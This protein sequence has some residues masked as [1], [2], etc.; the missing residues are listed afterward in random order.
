MAKKRIDSVTLE[1]LLHKLWQIADEAGIV[2]RRVSG[3][4]VVIEAKDM[5]AGLCDASGHIITSG[6]G[7]SAHCGVA[8][9]SVEHL[10]ERYSENPG[11]RDGDAFFINDPYICAMHQ[12][13]AFVVAPI[14]YQEELVAW[15]VTMTHLLDIG[16]ADPGG[17]TP[18]AREV[19]QEGIRIGGIKIAEGGMIRRDVIDSIVNM[20]R[21][22]GIVELDL[23]AQV[24]ASTT[25]KERLKELI[26]H[27]GMDTFKAVC[28][29][30]IK[31]S[32]L[33]LRARIAELPDGRWQSAVYVDDDSKTD[34]V[35]QIFVT[36]TKEGDSLT[37]DYTGT[38]EQAPSY[39]NVGEVGGQG[40]VFGAVAPLL[41]YDMPWSQ[42]VLNP[43]NIIIPKGTLVRAKFPT[44]C[45]LGTLCGGLVGAGNAAV[46]AVS[47][48]LNS[49]G[50]YEE[51]DVTALW[52]AITGA[53]I[54]AG[55]DQYGA[56]FVANF[57]DSEAA[58]GGA[59]PTGDGIDSGGHFFIP[60]GSCA[61]VET[62]EVTFPILYLYR[63]QVTDS[64][65]AGRERGGVGGEWGLMLHDAPEGEAVANIF[66]Y[67]TEAG[68]NAGI[69]GGYPGIG[70]RY[71]IVR[72]SDIIERLGRGDLPESIEDFK[73]N[74]EVLKINELFTLKSGDVF[75]FRWG[76]GGGYGDPIDRDTER[77]QQDVI[78]RLVSLTAARD[79]Y[80]AGIDPETIEIDVKKTEQ[81]REVIRQERLRAQKHSR[82]S[83]C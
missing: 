76:A 49:S 36:M 73:G 81:K 82:T 35:Y 59:T 30:A 70:F 26:E 23:R 53:P 57:M 77:V 55:V 79:I 66:G 4:I 54:I 83:D 1:I 43:L 38:S 33:K 75:S 14:F 34:R 7:V 51:L 37:F 65:G 3:S 32:E 74:L 56:S 6:V 16:G 41:A 80:G 2:L 39:S 71:R 50:N 64:G 61:N 31:Y 9:Y 22:P 21:V 52:G 48:M 46:G 44:P 10:I 42:G 8:R 29:E 27:Y 24:A 47:K 18:S 12:A 15:C 58:G 69:C 78:N 40:G 11:I 25:V 68:M 62:Y 19:F 67:G 72:G 17:A 5:F 20:T 13:D 28:E 45:S 63:R 60:G